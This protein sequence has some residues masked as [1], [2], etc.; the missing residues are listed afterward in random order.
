MV[1]G[2]EG[3][4]WALAG[5]LYQ[6]LGTGSITA[7]ASSSKPI[8]SGGESDDLDVLITLIG[9]GEGVRSFPERFSED[10]VFVQDDKCVIVE[11]KYSANLRK[12]GKPDL[13]KIIKKL[14]ES[15][16]EAKKQG[17][18]V[19]ACVIVT[20][21]EFTGHAGKLWE[22]EIAGD[23]D[24]KL[25][26]S[27]AQITRFTDILQKFGAEFGL[28]QREINE[29]IKKLLGYI[30]TETVYHYRPTIT[31][32]HLVES[33]TDY[34]LTKPLKTMCLELLWR[35]DL[36]KFGDFIRIDQWQDA[37]VNRAVNRDVFEKLIAAT[38]TRSLVCV[39]GNGGCG[40]SFV[41]WQ[42]LKYSVDPSYRCCAVEY[43]KNLKHDWIANTVHKWRGLP[44][45]IHQD[46]PQ[47]AIER[48][49]I[50][51]PDSR[52]PILWLALDGL[53]EVTASP[54]QIDLIREILQWFWDLD[55]EVG[56][57][58][59]SAATLIVSCRRKEDFEQ[60]W[61]HLPHDYPGAYPVTI[62]VGDFSDSEIE[63]A[64]SQSFPELYR[65]I[66]S[67]NGGHLSFLKE[68]SN[69]I[70]FDQD[71]EYTPQNS[72]N[73]DVWM[74]LKHPAMWRALLN[75]D[76]SARVNAIDGNEQAVYSLADHFV[77]W[78]HSK[79]LQRR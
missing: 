30:L 10:A 74:S 59:P 60:S 40:K 57:D 14:D 19:T 75:L 45:G 6:I 42:L 50:A 47:K 21:R 52:R 58:T 69:P 73:Q 36:K 38:S 12:I 27:C 61:L 44:E 9:V 17:E 22:A 29:G 11:F 77:K 13:E 26:Y 25:R 67:T 51:N 1:G 5:F 20:N 62:Q 64:A 41:I 54:Q 66:V 53:D 18:S 48:L 34:H 79:L 7:G 15:A 32:D 78:F 76:N 35:K 55:C 70:P 28:F 3:G 63:K 65:R 31:R 56:S 8:R 71:L 43:A 37:A 2:Q 46:T 49:I 24:Y 16:Q 68:S 23:R 33:F 72:I 39:Y 4:L